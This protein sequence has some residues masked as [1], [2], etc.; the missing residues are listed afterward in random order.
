MIADAN[1]YFAGEEP[2]A[3][4]KTNPKRME[5]ILYVTAEVLR[6]IAHSGAA[7]HAGSA[8]KLLDQ[9]GVPQDARDFA[10][11]RAEGAAQARNAAAAAASACSRAMSRLKARLRR[12]DAASLAAELLDARLVDALDQDAADHG[13]RDGGVA[14]PL[15][16]D[17][18]DLR[19]RRVEDGVSDV[20]TRED[21]PDLLA[22]GAPRGVV[23]DN[24]LAAPGLGRGRGKTEERSRRRH[25]H[26]RAT[27]G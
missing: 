21:G 24:A 9:L 6:Q 26:L 23:H 18:L 4:K 19:G 17:R 7:G 5:T 2:W 22:I 14:K 27:N 3:H 1:R 15:E 13:A 8:A 11:S 16:H 25:D 10:A 12:R 20:V